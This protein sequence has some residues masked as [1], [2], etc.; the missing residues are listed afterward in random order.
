LAAIMPTVDEAE[1][2]ILFTVADDT[3]SFLCY[4]LG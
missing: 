2:P 3:I 1:F 4:P